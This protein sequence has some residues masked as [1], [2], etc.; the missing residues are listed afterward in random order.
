MVELTRTWKAVSFNLIAILVGILMFLP[1]YWITVSSFRSQADIYS[2]AQSLVPGD[3]SLAN[4]DQLLTKTAFL[5]SIVNSV[6]VAVVVTIAG[7]FFA[8]LAGYAFAKLRFVGRDTIFTILL[9][10]MAIPTVVTLLPNFIVLGRLGLLDTLWSIILPQLALPFSVLWM[11]QYLRVSIPDAVLDAARVDGAGE[12]RIVIDI[13]APMIRSGLAGV[14]IWLF[15]G[16][17]NSLLLP[18]VY[19]SSNTNFTYPVFLATLQ[20]D[21]NHPMVHI[22]MAATV[23]STLPV[24]LLFLFLQRHFV[25]SAS[26]AGIDSA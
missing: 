16:S 17:W 6:A 23:A 9:G 10:S 21:L 3:L 24:V 13:V 14:A 1:L 25:A 22:V 11:R 19:L 20:G 15:L 4:Y 18:L 7:T 12:Y 8:A 26:S 2:T 5:H